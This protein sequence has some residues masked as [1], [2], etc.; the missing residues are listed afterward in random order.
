MR[1]HTGL[2]F[3]YIKKDILGIFHVIDIAF[4]LTYAKVKSTY[5]AEWQEQT[6]YKAPSVLAVAVGSTVELAAVA[7]LPWGQEVM[8]ALPLNFLREE[9]KEVICRA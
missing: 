6:Q 9:N 8:A 1:N 3:S 5:T 2:V 4:L 7:E